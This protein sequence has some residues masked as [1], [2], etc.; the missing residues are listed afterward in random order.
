MDI[1]SHRFGLLAA[2]F[3]IALGSIVMFAV[4]VSLTIGAS[5]GQQC[6]PV[7]KQPA[8]PVMRRVRSEDARA[9]VEMQA[10]IRY[11]DTINS[12]V[13]YLPVKLDSVQ[14][15]LKRDTAQLTLVTDCATIDLGMKIQYAD[16]SSPIYN[17]RSIVMDMPKMDSSSS[18]R[19]EPDMFGWKNMKLEDGYSYACNSRM[20]IYGYVERDNYVE[21]V[22]DK[23][24]FE[25][26]RE[27][28]DT[29]REMTF[30]PVYTMCE[31]PGDHKL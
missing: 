3:V 20:S 16:T 23:F 4:L 6:K 22:L 30:G 8:A 18:D 5:G 13:R 26:A 11:E 24:W 1:T 19:L 27:S 29:I 15:T 14:I 9:L 17:V 7:E 2:I 25:I 21:L 12:R 31:A 10:Y 28:S